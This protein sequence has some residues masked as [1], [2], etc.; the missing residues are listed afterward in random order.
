MKRC[1]T[2]LKQSKYDKRIIGYSNLKELFTWLDA[3]FSVH[4]NIRSHTVGAMSMG[5][6][7]IHF[8]SSKQKFNTKSTTESYLFGT[9]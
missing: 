3:S 1:F 7:I 4:P 2:F 8:C 5:C 9:S 6:V